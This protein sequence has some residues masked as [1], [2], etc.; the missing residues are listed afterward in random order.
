MTDYLDNSCETRPDLKGQVEKLTVRNGLNRAFDPLT[1]D[2][3]AEMRQWHRVIISTH[4]H[5][6][7]DLWHTIHKYLYQDE[8]DDQTAYEHGVI[9]GSRWLYEPKST[10]T[11]FVPMGNN[12]WAQLPVMEDTIQDREFYVRDPDL[13]TSLKLLWPHNVKIWWGES[14]ERVSESV[15]QDL[16]S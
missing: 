7:A 9:M 6:H 14:R 8:Q 1:C 12:Q 5:D 10:R 3:P 4:Y 16:F 2:N 13:V 15:Y 11:H